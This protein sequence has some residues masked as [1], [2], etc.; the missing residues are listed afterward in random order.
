[1]RTGT[2]G[3]IAR[4]SLLPVVLLLG[5]AGFAT[6]QSIEGC[7]TAECTLAQNQ[8]RTA[9]A[10]IS[11]RKEEFVLALRQFVV[12][13]AGFGGEGSLVR[14]SLDAMESALVRWDETIRTFETAVSSARGAET[15]LMLG[16]VYV[17]RHRL[18]DALREFHEAVRLGPQRADSHALLAMTYGLAGKVSDAAQALLKASALDSVDPFTFYE[19]A[20]YRTRMGDM[21]E[22]RSALQNFRGALQKQLAARRP[23]DTQ[24]TPFE[25]VVLLKQMAGETPFFPP[26]LYSSGFALLTQGYYRE[27]IVRFRQAAAVDPLTANS[28]APSDPFTQGRSALRQGDFRSAVSH[29]KEAAASLPR[30]AEVYRVLGTA[31]WADGQ[32]DASIDQFKAALR[33]NPNDER[34]WMA[35]ADVLATIGQFAQAEQVLKEALQ[36]IPASGQAHYD[37][38]RLYR[39][40]GMYPDSIRQL[41]EAA[42]LNPILGLDSLYEEIGA[43]DEIQADFQGAADAY[44]RRIE[45]NPNNAD[46]HRKLGEALLRQDRDDEAL[47]EFMTTAAIDA[48]SSA[49]FGGIAQVYLRAGDY[50]EAAEAS[51]RALEIDS[52]LKEARYALGTS[53]MRLGQ[54][55]E[56]AKQ[57]AE[58]QRL[59]TE[60]MAAARRQ[61]EVERLRRDAAVSLA[62]AEYEKTAGLLR[63][64]ASQEAGDGATYL[65]LGFA[66]L[67]AGHHSEAVVALQKASQLAPGADVHRYLA[68][69]YQ[70]LGRVEESRAELVLYQQTIQALKK[71]QLRKMTGNP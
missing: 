52:T 42:K 24:T 38:G 15:H 47:A 40:L 43:V 60:A 44:T 35:L 56:A 32:Y 25:R 63:E 36:R 55:E 58:F 68:E 61:S 71:E 57:I 2:R 6:A 39:A 62:N 53:L 9:T 54:V 67:M 17:G 28:D 30:R 50:A 59:Q 26:G 14:S 22:A 13:L 66:L 3:A 20:R 5:A 21:K 31:Y 11:V 16:T 48:R 12:A 19:L 7:V 69:A 4:G 64:A 29:L 37:L 1:M 41:E 46:A 65:A 45:V 8:A 27:A 33:A 49:A 70:A 34:S 51:R 23:P 10:Q 18:D